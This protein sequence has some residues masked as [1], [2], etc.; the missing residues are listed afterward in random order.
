MLVVLVREFPVQVRQSSGDIIYFTAVKTTGLPQW[1]T[2][3]VIFLLVAVA[4]TAIG[5]I[6][7]DLFRQLPSL[8]AYR[9]D[10]LGSLTGS[11]AFA[12]VS[13]LRAP[14][15]V[16]GLI[17]AAALLVLGGRRTRCGTA[18]AGGDGRGAALRV[19]GAGRV[20]VAVLQDRGDRPS[21]APV[22][23]RTRSPPTGCRTRASRR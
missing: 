20:L 18:A 10:L 15:L 8:E 5:K 21:R 11:A 4:M 9:W 17:A 14:S 3:P 2:L 13:W 1:V 12:G 22:R 16:W 7:A 23:G 6:T 19:A